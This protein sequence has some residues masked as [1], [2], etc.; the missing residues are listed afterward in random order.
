MIVLRCVRL[1][2]L[3]KVY[4][5]YFP[6]QVIE[7]AP[8]LDGRATDETIQNS[9]RLQKKFEFENKNLDCR[10]L[11]VYLSSASRHC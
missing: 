5:C 7:F 11:Y 4:C 1:N 2:T 3:A 6:R 8:V 9:Q 10:S